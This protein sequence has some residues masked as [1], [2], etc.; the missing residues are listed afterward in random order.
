[1]VLARWERQLKPFLTKQL[2]DN[3]EMQKTQQIAA[4]DFYFAALRNK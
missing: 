4:L 3:I 2:A 1:M